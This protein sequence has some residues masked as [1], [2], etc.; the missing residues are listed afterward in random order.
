MNQIK[1][2]SI[3]LPMILLAFDDAQLIAALEDAVDKKNCQIVKIG[4]PEALQ[5]LNLSLASFLF[6]EPHYQQLAEECRRRYPQIETFALENKGFIPHSLLGKIAALIEEKKHLEKRNQELSSSLLMHTAKLSNVLL[7]LKQEQRISERIQKKLLTPKAPSLVG[8]DISLHTTCLSEGGGDFF[9][10]FKPTEHILDFVIGDV[11]GK[12]LLATLVSLTCKS[13]IAHYADKQ[14]HPLYYSKITGWQKEISP[15][16]FIIT[17]TSKVLYPLLLEIDHFVS[18]IYGRFNLYK[19]VFS[20]I[21]CGYASFFLYENKIKKARMIH[22]KNLP[23]G[24]EES[25]SYQVTE[26]Y[27]GEDDCFIFFSDSL[28]KAKLK[29]ENISCPVFLQNLI[30]ANIQLDAHQLRDTIFHEIINQMHDEQLNDDFS[31]FVVKIN[32]LHVE[33]LNHRF[34]KF[35]SVISQLQAVRQLIKESCLKAPGDAQLLAKELEL[36][37]DEAFSNI[38]K[39]GYKGQ[40]GR[41]IYILVDYQKDGIAIEL[42]DQGESF[43][44]AEVPPPNLYGDNDTGYGWF[45]IKQLVDQIHYMPKSTPAGWNRLRLFKKYF[46]QEGRMEITHQLDKDTL[47][48]NLESENLDSRSNLEFKDKV[49]PLILAS[50]QSNVII[51]LEKVEFIDSSGLGAL[52]S[53]SRQMKTKGGKLKL[54]AINPPVWAIF[55]LVSMHKVFSIYPTLEQAL[56]SE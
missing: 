34:S 45:L 38:V 50:E 36:V 48:I 32:Q 53:L 25:T 4:T 31:I 3:D 5:Y 47:I 8:C 7:Q 55:E 17:N 44:P 27:F 54:V 9:D 24:I 20:F 28:L 30:E 13:K 42:S 35:N 19:R 22:I 6:Y 41:A 33:H 2:S 10:F 49:M 12:G 56:E 37:T 43:D 39:H 40:P 16:P 26:L 11:I 14:F 52:L 23:I 29:N 1:E 46:S 51:N 18:L 21:N 15:L